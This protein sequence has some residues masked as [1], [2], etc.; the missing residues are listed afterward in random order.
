VKIEESDFN[1][2]KRLVHGTKMAAAYWTVRT[3]S[4]KLLMVEYSAAV[5]ETSAKVTEL[6]RRTVVIKAGQPALVSDNLKVVL[7][8]K[9]LTVSTDRWKM[10]AERSSF[11]FAHLS[12]NKKKV[13]LDVSIAPLYNADSDVVAPHGIIGQGY[14]GDAIGVDGKM[15]LD[16][17]AEMTTSAQAEGAIEGVWQDYMMD[18]EFSTRFQYSRFDSMA[19][20]PRDVAK[21]TGA[22]HAI[23]SSSVKVGASDAESTVE[24]A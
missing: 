21:L 23:G 11:P 10:T 16:R 14:D 1:W 3:H 20:K 15:D 9:A 18:S 7:V 17:S 22:K 6:N 4:G 24:V 2:A 13:L 12:A 19:A 8:D 5:K